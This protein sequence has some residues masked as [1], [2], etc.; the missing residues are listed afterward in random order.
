MSPEP[1]TLSSALNRQQSIIQMVSTMDDD[2]FEDDDDEEGGL[3]LHVV[4]DI[5]STS[6]KDQTVILNL[7]GISIFSLVMTLASEYTLYLQQFQT[8]LLL[9]YKS[10]GAVSFLFLAYKYRY[11][12]NGNGKFK[13]SEIILI[14]MILFILFLMNMPSLTVIMMEHYVYKRNK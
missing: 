9:F 11:N 4:T 10:C 8:V 1:V 12:Y 14:C 7:L 6:K 5:E 13:K 3:R 2:E